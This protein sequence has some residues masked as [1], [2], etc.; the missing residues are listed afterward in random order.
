ML[1]IDVLKSIIL[2]MIRIQRIVEAFGNVSQGSPSLQHVTKWDGISA[3][4]LLCRHPLII[5]TYSILL[6]KSIGYHHLRSS[7]IFGWSV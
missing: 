7:L 4:W 2:Q 1:V 5:M 3:S 6:S